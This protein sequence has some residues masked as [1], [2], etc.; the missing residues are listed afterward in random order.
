MT[1]VRNLQLSFFGKFNNVQLDTPLVIKLLENLQ[2]DNFITS[3]VD[4]ATVNVLTGKLEVTSRL[5]LI[6]KNKKWNIVFLD[7]RI[8]FNFNYQNDDEQ[9]IG[10]LIEFAN[11]LI[12]KTFNALG[13]EKG[14]RLG[15]NIRLIKEKLDDIKKKQFGL[16]F[17]NPLKI[18]SDKEFSEWGVKFNAKS[19][20]NFSDTKKEISNRILEIF[21]QDYYKKQDEKIIKESEINILFDINTSQDNFE[22]RFDGVDLINY[23]KEAQKFILS[24]LIEID[25]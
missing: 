11:S 25:N 9:S 4:S 6:T 10:E 3:S 8:D 1:K 17:I 24:S 12:T 2:N 13:N 14:F 23:S 5:Q 18:C 22:L 15:V 16:R 7:N 21:Q 19:E 20:L